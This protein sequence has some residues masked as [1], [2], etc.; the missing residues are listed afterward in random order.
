MRN[1]PP[2][3]PGQFKTCTDRARGGSRSRIGYVHLLSFRRRRRTLRRHRRIAMRGDIL[4][5]QHRRGTLAEMRGAHRRIVALVAL[6]TAA[7]LAS[8]VTPAAIGVAAPRVCSLT[9][10]GYLRWNLDALVY[11]VAASPQLCLGS[12]DRR[13]MSLSA[14]ACTL[15]ACCTSSYQP[16]FRHPGATLLTLVRR[17]RPPFVSADRDLAAIH[18]GHNYIRCRR[19]WWLAAA[20]GQTGQL[21]CARGGRERIRTSPRLNGRRPAVAYTDLTTQGALVWDLEALV[22]EWHG[23]PAAR[24]PA[25]MFRHAEGTSF[26]LRPPG[27]WQYNHSG[28]IVVVG[29]WVSC[30]RHRV[31]AGVDWIA[32][33]G[34]DCLEG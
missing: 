15:P 10:R 8:V 23:S 12:P 27:Q 5:A 24:P 17:S 32:L 29:R 9:A 7:A 34:L 26:R 1:R 19:G 28:P 18:V 20:D 3:E 25:V 22:R 11:H 21:T 14:H 13:T 16:L 2:H 30:G 31:L 6:L 4:T 33:G